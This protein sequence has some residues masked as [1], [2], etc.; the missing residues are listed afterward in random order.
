MLLVGFSQSVLPVT[1]RDLCVYCINVPDGG[2]LY[3]LLSGVLG[4]ILG[5]L[6]ASGWTGDIEVRLPWGQ[7]T[8]R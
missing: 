5:L 1:H 6:E 4:S 8:W 3:R 2:N 7:S